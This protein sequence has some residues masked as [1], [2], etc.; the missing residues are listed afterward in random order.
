[1]RKK[2][3][4]EEARNELLLISAPDQI[5]SLK[6]KKNSP[7]THLRSDAHRVLFFNDIVNYYGKC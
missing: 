5:W 2:K 7:S 3:E 1:V 6:N 4:E